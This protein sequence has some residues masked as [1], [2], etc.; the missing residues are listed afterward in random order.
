MHEEQVWLLKDWT[1]AEISLHHADSQ[2][3]L[4][5]GTSPAAV[6]W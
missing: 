5:G 3:G 2:V 4:S 6:L 1:A